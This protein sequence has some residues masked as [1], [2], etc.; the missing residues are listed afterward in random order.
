[1]VVLL[2]NL[3]KLSA[4][5]CAILLMPYAQAEGKNVQ[6]CLTQADAPI[7]VM[8]CFRG[9]PYR[10]DGALDEA[11]RWTLWADQSQEFTSPGLNCSGLT[12]AISN[13][14]FLQKVTLERAKRDRLD[15]SGAGA[16]MGEDWDFGLDLIL[17]LT[18]GLPSRVLIPDPYAAVSVD[19]AQ[20]SAHD[21]R[22]VEI[23]GPNFSEILSSIQ[24]NKLYYFAISKPDRR[25]TGGISF[26]HVGIILKDGEQIWMYHATAKG[27]VYRV[28]LAGVR[29]LAW[30]SKYYGP[31]NQGSKYMQLIEVPLPEKNNAQKNSPN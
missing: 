16:A 3:L 26:Y 21:L 18:E 12:T 11:D 24:S 6:T 15:D 13:S 31:S 14:L 19:S 5:F 27:G 7:A 4:F 28:D 30:M 29:G 17:N 2:N 8:E 22:G 9:L 1:M 23:G 25:F 10:F 20:W